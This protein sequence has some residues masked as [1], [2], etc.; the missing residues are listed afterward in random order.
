MKKIFL[1]LF[2]GF[3][4]AMSTFAQDAKPETKEVPKQKFTRTTFNSTKIINMQS[5]EMVSKG[6]MQ[7]LISH[8]FSPLWLDGASAGENFAQ[9]LGLNSGVA[10]TYLSFDY[11]ATNWLNVGIAA[12]GSSK[13]EGFAKFKILRQQ[14]GAKN[15]P[16]SIAWFSLAS[17]NA[18]KNP[19]ITFGWNKFSYMNQ[20]LI[21][22]KFNDKFSL[23]LTPAWI[24]YN[25]APY[26]ANNSNEVF[27]L[28]LAGKYKVASKMNV[29]FEYNRQLNM[30][31]NIISKN[32]SI[33]NYEPNLVSAGVEI[34][35]GGHLFQ[36]YIGNTTASSNIEQ[37]SRNTGT[38]DFNHLAFG[39]TIN[40]TLS[41][42]KE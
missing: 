6:N 23:E 14:T 42:K 5:V 15:V 40:R 3:G 27:S 28:G 13:W 20:L 25:L 24:H 19:D 26:G 30:Y 31:D 17:V 4:L 32:G 8:H 22:R 35:T 11:T 2:A 36:F 18:A 41:L 1:L 33:V 37:L 29:T 9:L 38:F 34:G 10:K 16:V 7:F 21:A 39:F 12:A